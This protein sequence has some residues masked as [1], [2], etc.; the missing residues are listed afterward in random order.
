[1]PSVCQLYAVYASPADETH[2][3]SF[4]I[5]FSYC[6]DVTFFLTVG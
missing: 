2:V 6:I 1:V 5:Q 3:G 4:S